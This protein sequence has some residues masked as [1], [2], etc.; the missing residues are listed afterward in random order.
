MQQ[1][2]QFFINRPR[3]YMYNTSDFPVRSHITH[4]SHTELPK[5]W[6]AHCTHS[7]SWYA[8]G[9]ARILLMRQRSRHAIKILMSS[10]SAILTKME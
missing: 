3:W 1:H 4:L 5:V 7:G 10:N 6:I 2:P 8:W 9:L